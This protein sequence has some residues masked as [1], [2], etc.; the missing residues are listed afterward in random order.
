M[1]EI[2]NL[3]VLRHLRTDPSSHLLYYRKARLKRSG[4]GL[5]FWFLPLKASIAEVPLDDRDLPIVFHGRSSDFQD[6]TAQGVLTF[7]VNN[8]QVISQRIDFTVDLAR[9]VY[10]RQP[11]EKLA[12][13]MSQ[14]AQQYAWSHIARTPIRE[15]LADGQLRIREQIEAGFAS[16]ATIQSMGISV[17]SV[18]I[19]SVRPVADL[20]KALEAPIREQIQQEA[21]KASFGRRALAVKM[22][23]AI[24]ENELTN[25]IELAKQQEGLI[26]Q[27]GQNA[28]RQATEEAQAAEIS[29]ESAA[30]RTRIDALAQAERVRTEGEARSQALGLE[31]QVRVQAERERMEVYRTVPAPVLLGLAAQALAGKLERIDHLN[32]SPELL[33]PMLRDLIEANTQRLSTERG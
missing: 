6:V 24:Q 2:I 4:P 5:S 23:R 22:E 30:R 28:R 7:R 16:D 19:S 25:Q 18:R 3:R 1:A 33:G 8:P 31:E 14:L 17:V 9:G 21:D 10:L 26:T 11:L 13:L 32:L 12:L 27:K 29:S 20:E 15:V